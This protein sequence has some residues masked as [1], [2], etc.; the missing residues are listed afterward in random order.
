[1]GGANAAM[2]SIMCA[3]CHGPFGVSATPDSPSLAG[4][5]KPK[6]IRL[7]NDFKSGDRKNTIM[8]RIAKGYSIIEINKMADYFSRQSR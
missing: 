2:L 6:F 8:K 5:S 4:M 7:M 1:M 3:E